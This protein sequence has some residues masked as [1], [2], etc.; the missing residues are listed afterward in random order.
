M[1]T[2]AEGTPLATSKL[3]NWHCYDVVSVTRTV[4]WVGF[5]PSYDY[6]VVV[7]NPHGYDN[8]SGS[9]DTSDALITL[10]WAEFAGSI[11]GYAIN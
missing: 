10:S 11:S 9:G 6:T 4:S 7:R 8:G 5:L 3:V 2:W 1:R